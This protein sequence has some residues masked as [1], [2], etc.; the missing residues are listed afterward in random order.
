MGWWVPSRPPAQP[1]HSSLRTVPCFP[2]LCSGPCQAR[3][4]PCSGVPGNTPGSILLQHPSFAWAGLSGFR[5]LQ[6]G[7]LQCDRGCREAW[8]PHVQGLVDSRSLSSQQRT[9]RVG[10]LCSGCFSAH[11]QFHLPIHLTP[12]PPSPLELN[13]RF[14]PSRKSSQINPGHSQLILHL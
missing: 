1:D 10:N 3:S 9:I 7:G 4:L 6:S 11:E 12:H 8:G 5:S 2:R 14:T 13:S